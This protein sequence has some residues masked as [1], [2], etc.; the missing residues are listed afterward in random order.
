M[1]G[2]ANPEALVETDWRRLKAMG[3]SDARIGELS[4]AARFLAQ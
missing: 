2:Y 4:G 3:L 1:S